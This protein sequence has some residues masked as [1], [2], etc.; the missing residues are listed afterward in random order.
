MKVNANTIRPGNILELNGKLWSVLKINIL[1]PGKGGAF[2]QIEMRDVLSGTKT[3]DRFRTQETV[4]KIQVDESDYQFL[5]ADGDDYTFMNNQTY[6]QIVLDKEAI[7]YPAVFLQDGMVVSIKMYE[8]KPLGVELPASAV[9]EIV[10]ADPVVK[11][12]TVS[13]SY[14]PAILDNGEKIQVPP[15]IEAGTKV[16]VS[17][18]DGSYVEKAK[19]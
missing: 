12:Q 19:G 4:E 1:Q 10:E 7:G 5:F 16:V 2:I 11:G 9:Y 18:A 8:G 17:I 3:N 13:S 14:K 15:H 6:D